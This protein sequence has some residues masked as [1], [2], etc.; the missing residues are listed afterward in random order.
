MH[1]K[2]ILHN[3][4]FTTT[5]GINK[6]ERDTKRAL[7]LDIEL[8]TDTR[9]AAQ[10]DSIT[11]TIS[12]TDVHETVKN[13]IEENEWDLIEAVAEAAATIILATF[14]VDGV[15][16]RVKKPSALHDRNVD[17]TAVEITRMK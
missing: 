2:I 13:L 9:K 16:I 10:A 7:Y 4:L 5:I 6:T 15:H 8:F 1:D 12:Y 14:A 17:Y 3:C 11:A